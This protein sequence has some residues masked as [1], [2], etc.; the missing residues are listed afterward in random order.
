MRASSLGMALQQRR[1][2][3][4]PNSGINKL[5]PGPFVA[6]SKRLDGSENPSTEDEANK[7]AFHHGLHRAIGIAAKKDQRQQ[8]SKKKWFSSRAIVLSRQLSR[9]AEPVLSWSPLC[10]A[11]M[12]SSSLTVLCVTADCIEISAVGLKLN[13]SRRPFNKQESGVC[14]KH[15]R[16]RHRL[17]MI[18]W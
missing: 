5:C 14:F 13:G 4:E 7:R 10:S 6:D 16:R 2:R 3:D 18:Y 9:L 15:W 1:K 11:L 12:I 17:D 8:R